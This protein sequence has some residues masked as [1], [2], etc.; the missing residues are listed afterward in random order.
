MRTFL[1]EQFDI[2]LPVLN[3]PMSGTAGARLAAAVS[4]GGALGVLGVGPAVAHEWLEHEL[5]ELQDTEKPYAVG[6]LGWALERDG[7]PMRQV[8]AVRPDLIAVSYGDVE[9]WVAPLHDRGIAITAQ[10]GTLHEAYD[11][12]DMGVDFIV[13]RGSE[14]GGHGR[15]EV[16]SLPLLQ[17]VLDEV[18]TPV[19]AAGGIATGR[20]LAAVIAAGAVGAWVGTAFTCC[21]E[22]DSGAAVRDAIVHAEL[23]DTVYG[24]VFDLTQQSNGWPEAYGGRALRNQFTD[25]WLGREPELTA[26]TPAAVAASDQVRKAR[27]AGDLRYAPVYAGQAAGLVH[28]E[29][30]VAEVLA[31]FT[32]A[33]AHLRRAAESAG[34]T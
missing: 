6:F 13:V 11:L 7:A 22:A 33:A 1:T 20:G 32:T 12:E 26:R 14:G 24:R 3:A 30:S 17:A 34:E 18:E 27:Q 5:N 19:I 9:R 4:I 31:E 28:A 23:T 21:A 10:A 16:A 29:R 25:E 8:M 15:N 2:E